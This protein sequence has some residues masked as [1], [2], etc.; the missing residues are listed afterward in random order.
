M[1]RLETVSL[2][3]SFS[4]SLSLSDFFYHIIIAARRL[5]PNATINLELLNLL[6]HEQN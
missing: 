3:L 5:S 1:K 2:S 4:L 6:N